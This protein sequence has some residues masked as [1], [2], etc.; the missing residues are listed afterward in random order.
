VRLR[1]CVAQTYDAAQAHELTRVRTRAVTAGTTLVLKAGDAVWSFCEIGGKKSAYVQRGVVDSLPK[2]DGKEEGHGR[3]GGGGEV[4]GGARAGDAAGGALYGVS[5]GGIVQLVPLSWIVD[6]VD[7]EVGS[8]E[9]MD[10]VETILAPLKRQVARL[11]AEQRGKAPPPARPDQPR[12]GARGDAPQPGPSSAGDASGDAGPGAE[13]LVVV[14]TCARCAR[15]ADAPGGVG[16]G[17]GGGAGGEAL[18]AK[19]EELERKLRQS[20]EEVREAEER[21]AQ[22]EHEIKGLGVALERTRRAEAAKAE[23]EALVAALEEQIQNE[24]KVREHLEEAHRDGTQRAEEQQQQAAAAA[25]ALEG[26]LDD[27]HLQVSQKERETRR[28]SPERERCC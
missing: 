12:H 21:A 4:W 2:E 5:F 25:R 8:M 27:V 18:A 9:A 22:A 16:G 1:A 26:K 14:E 7:E 17:A 11:L 23:L 20:E 13:R 6:K 28:K 15:M 3:G 24:R 10:Q 19:V